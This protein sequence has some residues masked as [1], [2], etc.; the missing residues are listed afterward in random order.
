MVVFIVV[1]ALLG[2]LVWHHFSG[3]VTT[4]TEELQAYSM[5]PP[6]LS[7]YT[8]IAGQ[9]IYITVTSYSPS[10]GQYVIIY[11]GNG[12]A[13]NSTTGSVQVTYAYPGH[14]LVYYTIY[15][16]GQ[17]VGSSQ[18]NLLEVLV[19]PPQFNESYAQL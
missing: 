10:P 11:T 17:L 2:V 14:Y 16:D 13:V 5:S 19:A 6:A 8:A 15:K 9:P 7:S 12:S 18:G 1:L 4:N 3:D